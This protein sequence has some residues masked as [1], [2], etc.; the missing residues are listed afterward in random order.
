[1]KDKLEQLK[2]EALQKIENVEG[3]EFL[4]DEFLFLKF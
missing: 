3:L 2:K 1:M 4:N